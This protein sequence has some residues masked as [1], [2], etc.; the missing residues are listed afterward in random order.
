MTLF[1]AFPPKIWTLMLVLKHL[2][3][4][5]LCKKSVFSLISMRIFQKWTK[6]KIIFAYLFTIVWSNPI[7]SVLMFPKNNYFHINWQWVPSSSAAPFITLFS[8]SWCTNWPINDSRIIRLKFL[9][10]EI[11]FWAILLPK[12]IN[13]N[14]KRN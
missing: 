5:N 13:H 8:Y 6:T 3:A 1:H 7:F 10:R 9:S 11:D 14:S 4:S 2:Q 12:L